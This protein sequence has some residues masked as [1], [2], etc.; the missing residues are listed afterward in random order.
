MEQK[1]ADLQGS[2]PLATTSTRTAAPL[3]VLCFGFET[4]FLEKII[5]KRLKKNEA[6]YNGQR[7]NPD[8]V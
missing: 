7:R 8:G 6:R 4:A 2:G 5:L 3:F 1:K